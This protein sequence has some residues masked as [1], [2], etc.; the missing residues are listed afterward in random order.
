MGV[1]VVVH[2]GPNEQ[3][4]V[5]VA[6]F[7]ARADETPKP[8]MSTSNITPAKKYPTLFPRD[9]GFVYMWL[10]SIFGLSLRT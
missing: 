4:L 6:K 8:I 10:A 9:F 2:G 5:A 7:D 3:S 1:A